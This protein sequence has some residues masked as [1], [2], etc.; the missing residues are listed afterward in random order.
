MKPEHRAY[1]T[2]DGHVRIGSVIYGIGAEVLDPDGWVWSLIEAMDGTRSVP[3][4]LAT[5]RETHPEVPME[6]LREALADLLAAGFVE[7]AAAPVPPELSEREQDRYSR[8]V[9]L[10]RWMDLTPRRSPWDVQ[11]RLRNSRVL[12]LGVGGTGGYAAQTLVASGV[13]HLHCVEPDVVERSNLNRQPL[14]AEKDIGLPKL[15]AALDALRARNPDVTVT[16]ERREVRDPDDLA[17]LM[18]PGYDLLLLAADRPPEIRRWANRRC[19]AT[20]TPWV[21][22]GYHGPLVTV[23]VHRPGS[24]ACW[25]CHRAGEVARRDLR[26]GPGQDEEV[27]SPRLDWN[28]AN[29]VTAAL[30]G[31]LQTHAA[32]ALLTGVPAMEPG[33]RF[34]INLMVPGD[35]VLERFDRLPDCPACG[36]VPGRP[37]D[38]DG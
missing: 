34:G 3:S 8:S 17:E 31:T 2:T 33:F 6:D 10:Q 29:A 36:D 35:P 25:E 7:D 37:Q 23:G 32:L 12:L 16:G 30:S 9:P 19:L 14:F 26:V 15:D 38:T 27:A 4:V 11:L 21:D 24:G 1:R 28:P 18:S 20:G 13:G 22:A 5:V